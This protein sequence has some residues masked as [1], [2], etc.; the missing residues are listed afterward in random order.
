MSLPRARGHR[1]GGGPLGRGA[2]ERHYGAEVG[3]YVAAAAALIGA[4]VS[5]YGVSESAGAQ[6]DAAKFNA[7]VADNQALASRYSAQV[8]TENRRTAFRRAQAAQRSRIGG[9]GVV[10]DE[11]SALLV[12]MDAA[13]Q[14]EVDL[15]RVKYAGDIQAA[16]PESEARFQ[17][18]LGR[19]AG[20]AG[21]LR[22]GSTL[23]S[24]IGSAAGSYGRMPSSTAPLDV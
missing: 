22:T 2:R 5:A 15:Q 9:S 18:F 16:I 3:F 23:L 21:Q 8:E 7:K 17:G 12:Q 11:G 10:G 4:G 24:G 6:Q 20:P 14:A 19:R 13:E 1:Y